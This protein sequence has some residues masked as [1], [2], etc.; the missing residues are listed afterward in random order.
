MSIMPNRLCSG[1]LMQVKRLL[2]ILTEGIGR[3]D[4]VEMVYNGHTDVN[5]SMDTP[6][7]LYYW[8]QVV[9]YQMAIHQLIIRNLWFHDVLD[10]TMIRRGI[11]FLFMGEDD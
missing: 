8:Q 9:I 2:T 4:N 6:F 1:T 10:I 7:A 11:L 3:L 5:T